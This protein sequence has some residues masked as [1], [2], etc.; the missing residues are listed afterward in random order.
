MFVVRGENVY[1]SAIED[2][3][4]GIKGFGDEFRVII[5]REK[6]MDEMIVQAEYGPEVDSNLVPELK[7]KL[8]AGLKARGLRT[9]V[10]MMEPNSLE[11]T[12]FKAKRVIDK[13]DLYEEMTK[14]T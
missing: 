9:V 14:R 6:A 2:V 10:Q 4:R 7:V 1:P 5:T 13:R 12:E 11:R 8:E 3:I